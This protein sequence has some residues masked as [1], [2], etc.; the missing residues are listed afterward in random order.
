MVKDEVAFQI[1]DSEQNNEGEI[2]SGVN[3]KSV[4]SQLA[5]GGAVGKVGGSSNSGNGSGGN[6]GSTSGTDRRKGAAEH[7]YTLYRSPFAMAPLIHGFYDQWESIEKDVLLSYLILPL[8]TYPPIHKFLKNSRKDSSL[9][10]L[11][12]E[13]SRI[14]GLDLRIDELKSITNAA[15]LILTAENS[16]K[17]NDDLSIASINKVREEN[18]DSELLKLSKKLATVLSGESVIS[19]YRTLG[20]NSL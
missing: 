12:S 6:N 15:L 2:V 4:V 14:V 8:V 11:T 16:L 9:R 13:A 7:I 20:L 19:I 18:T 3:N 17:I 5:S 1:T 10:T